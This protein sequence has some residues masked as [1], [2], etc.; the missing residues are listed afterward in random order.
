LTTQDKP[1]NGTV[2]RIVL[3]VAG[4]GLV[5]YGLY[6]VRQILVLVLVAAFF[7]VGLDPLVRALGRAGLRR[8]V[9]VAVVFLAVLLFIGGFVASITPP[10]VRQTQNLATEIPQFAERLSTRSGRFQ[11]LDRQYDISGRLRKAVNDVPSLAGSSLGGALGVARSV[12]SAIFSVLTV[13]VLTLYFLLDLPNLIA[14]A[15]KLVA[16]SRRKEMQ[17]HAGKVFERI[18]GYLLGN[19]GVSVVAGVTTFIAL[20]ALRVP[21]ALPLAMWVAIADLIPMVGA[22]LG[23]IPAVIV[24]FF[25][26]FWMGIGAVIFFAIY[27]QVENYYVAPRVMKR[28]V[29]ISAAAVILAALIGAT[30][31]GFVGALLAIPVA[32]SIKVLTQEIWL[33]RQEAG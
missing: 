3:V 15:G 5:L 25:G 6:L 10:L 9:A 16:K 4:L 18:S 1:S 12:A 24:A 20:T 26:G 33:P 7:A 28:A 31:L 8:G 22:T 23:A 21:Y 29:D 13:I 30:L 27:Q 11:D 32:A 19:I 2:A 17:Q 14:G